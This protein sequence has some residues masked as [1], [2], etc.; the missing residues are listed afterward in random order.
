MRAVW[1]GRPKLLRSF[2]L[3]TEPSAAREAVKRH[4]HSVTF[5]GG[6]FR[7][8]HHFASIAA[9]AFSS[10]SLP[11]VSWHESLDS[12][13]EAIRATAPAFSSNQARP[14]GN[15]PLPLPLPLLERRTPALPRG[16][17]KGVSSFLPASWFVY[18]HCC[19]HSQGYGMVLFVYSALLSRGIDETRGDMDDPSTALIGAHS[20]CTQARAR[21]AEICVI[22]AEIRG[23]VV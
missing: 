10:P 3:P 7:D 15:V 5:S 16:L 17:P 21:F 23:D 18:V 22:C 8:G 12:L 11:R 13:E 2:L 6:S 4:H 14:A 1:A 9:R 20:Y 19:F